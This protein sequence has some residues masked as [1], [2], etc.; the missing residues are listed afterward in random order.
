MFPRGDGTANVG[1]LMMSTSPSF[2][3]VNPANLLDGFVADNAG[4]WH[5]HGEPVLPPSGGRIPL[6]TS[7]LPAAGPTYLVVGDA[8]GAAN[9]MSGAGVEYALETGMLAGSVLDEALRTGQ[10]ASLQRY[11]KLLEERYGTYY[12]VGRLVDRLLGRPSLASWVG[13][14][15]ASRPA[16]ARSL[17]RVTGNSLRPGHAG[18]T[19][20]A[21]R[22]G[23]ALTSVAPDA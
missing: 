15:A 14:T 19:E 10:A 11:P 3:V 21:Y 13:R 7:V 16:F 9:P 1:V 17:V 12:K 6:G 22:L 23:A 20:L 4:R 2:R 5:L 18:A 8:A